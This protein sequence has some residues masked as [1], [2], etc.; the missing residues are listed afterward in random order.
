[1]SIKKLYLI[2]HGKSEANENYDILFTKDDKDIQL[3]EQGYHDAVQ[4]GKTLKEM[5]TPGAST[6]FVVSP[7][8]RAF[9]TYR[10]ASTVLKDF[11][12]PC[13]HEGIV[14][15][16]MNLKDHPVNWEK[17]LKYKHSKWSVEQHLHV[18]FDGGESLADV[19]ER[20]KTFLGFVEEL[21][22]A[23]GHDNIVVVSHGQFIKMVL[24]EMDGTDPQTMTHP[25]NGEIIV[26]EVK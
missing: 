26:R 25:K 5:L 6:I 16:D 12:E 13:I 23:L 15:H 9:Q 3:A 10:I 19:R 11:S 18:R 7:W 21:A 2:R 24:A 20:A 22:H 8:T 14:E 1:M 4:V 17:F